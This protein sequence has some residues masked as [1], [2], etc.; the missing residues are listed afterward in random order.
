MVLGEEQF[1]VDVAF[2][3]GKV[4]VER[5]DPDP[6]GLEQRHIGDLRKVIRVNEQLELRFEL[7]TVLP[8]VPGCQCVIPGH[9]FGQRSI[10]H[11]GLLRLGY[12]HHACTVQPGHIFRRT[13]RIRKPL[14]TQHLRLGGASVF[15]QDP[16]HRFHR[17]PFTIPGSGTVQDEHALKSRI[18]AHGIADRLLQVTDPVS[19]TLEY[20]IQECQPTGAGGSR[21]IV[22]FS[23]L[24][25]TVCRGVWTE[26]EITQVNRAV[27]AIERIFIHVKSIH[28]DRDTRI[29]PGIFDHDISV[30]FL[31]E[32]IDP[33]QEPV[34]GVFTRD[35]IGESEQDVVKV[36]CHFGDAQVVIIRPPD[37]SVVDIPAASRVIH[38]DNATVIIH[39]HPCITDLE[40][41]I[42]RI[43]VWS[44][45]LD[46]GIQT[47][48]IRSKGVALTLPAITFFLDGGNVQVAEVIFRGIL[49]GHRTVDLVTCQNSIADCNLAICGSTGCSVPFVSHQSGCTK[50]PIHLLLHAA[51]PEAQH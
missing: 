29:V 26:A 6:V 37:T 21:I 30:L 44:Q 20:L 32:H 34:S 18:T 51:T 16:Q 41:F 45:G 22:N 9:L 4:P 31:I 48:E 23:H 27:V 46:C 12:V 42:T 43:R 8:E 33:L 28:L 25:Q 40:R 15:T 19:I 49:A 13:G 10:D 50:D 36:L 14:L 2:R 47:A 5:D 17:R 7:E 1:Q 35:G 3:F 38:Q 24:R 11:H 39:E